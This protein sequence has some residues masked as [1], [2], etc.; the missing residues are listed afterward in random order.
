MI[1]VVVGGTGTLGNE[2]IR[3]LTLKQPNTEIRCVSRCEL[4]QKELQG[5]FPK[6]KCY[7]G[8]IRD[9]SSLYEPFLGADAVFHVAA[10]KHI[11]TLED[12]PEECIKTNIHGTI[13]VCFVAEQSKVKNVVFSSTDKAVDPINVYGMCKAISEKI[14]YKYNRRKNSTKYSVFRWGNIATSRGA[15]IHSFIRTL[16]EEQCV[17]VTDKTMTRFWLKIEDA[18]A[19]LLENY[20]LAPLD[21][22]CIP[23]MIKSAPLMDVIETLANIV[24]IK[25]YKVKVVGLRKGEK[26]H[27]L[28]TSTHHPDTISS[29]TCHKFTKRELK[30]FLTE[31]VAAK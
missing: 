4:K 8:D 1:A 26:I 22:A 31:C 17:Y 11:D 18:V 29:E 10:L 15:A 14:L 21:R 6:V 25:K 23:P 20:E 19:F 12:N 28:M 16:K 30:K 9:K 27:E 7:L 5:R 24:K 13:N 3:Q 2:I